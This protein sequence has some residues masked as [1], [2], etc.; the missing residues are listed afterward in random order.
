MITLFSTPTGYSV[1][2]RSDAR[3]HDTLLKRAPEKEYVNDFMM[4]SQ[5][6]IEGQ[7]D[8]GEKNL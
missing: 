2:A 6:S 7:C 1:G 5:R 8:A 4:D 3:S